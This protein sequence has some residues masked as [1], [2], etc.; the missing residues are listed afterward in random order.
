MEKELVI[1]DSNILIDMMR[2][3]KTTLH[4]VEEIGMENVVISSITVIEVLNGARNR[5]DFNKIENNIKDIP[6][7]HF[8]E[9]ISKMAEEFSRKF[10]MAN[11]TQVP[12]LIIGATAIHFNLK[13]FTHNKKD[14]R[15]IPGIQ[16]Y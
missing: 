9:N 4:Q 14:F 6:V 5:M 2:S 16:L 1:L 13:L 10:S 3:V 11:P 15:F 12:Y 7:I 8:T